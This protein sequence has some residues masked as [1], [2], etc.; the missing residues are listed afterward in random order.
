MINQYMVLG[1]MCHAWQECKDLS[2]VAMTCLLVPSLIFEQG[3]R[4]FAN[5]G[6]EEDQNLCSL[7]FHFSHKS[8]SFHG[9]I[10][11]KDAFLI[12]FFTFFVYQNFKQSCQ[13]G[14]V[15]QS[16]VP[17]CSI[18]T[19]GTCNSQPMSTSIPAQGTCNS[20]PTSTSIRGTIN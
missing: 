5:V 10:S 4:C 14:S 1:D 7:L 13:S 2:A 16:I 11:L 9:F 19:Q 12:Q 8:Q 17:I 3:F 6:G 18:P 15:G 20:Q